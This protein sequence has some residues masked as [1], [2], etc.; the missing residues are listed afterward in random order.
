MKKLLKMSKLLALRKFVILVENSKNEAV[1]YLELIL[2]L[3]TA[4][5]LYHHFR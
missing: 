3:K 2:Y 1:H 5:L 4:I